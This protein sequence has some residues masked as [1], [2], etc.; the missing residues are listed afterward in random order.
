MGDFID[1][2]AKYCPEKTA[3]ALS[4]MNTDIDT[5]K[6]VIDELTDVKDIVMTKEEIENFCARYDT[7]PA[8]F[9]FTPGG[10]TKEEAIN[11]FVEKFCK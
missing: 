10:Y 7:V 11:A 3:R 1:R 5:Y 8:N 4:I 6:K 9:T 2:A